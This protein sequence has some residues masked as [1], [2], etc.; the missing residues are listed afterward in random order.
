[1]FEG[2]FSGFQGYF[3]IYFAICFLVGWYWK[4]RGRSCAGG[5][6]CSLFFTPVIGLIVGAI[7][8]PSV[9]KVEL[10]QQNREP[11]TADTKK[12]PSCAEMVKAEA[13]V[14]RYCGREI[15]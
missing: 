10:V 9:Q 3:F 11:Q 13:K 15:P 12:C 7:I 1:M 6:F 8:S 2:V 14:C 4:N 5:F